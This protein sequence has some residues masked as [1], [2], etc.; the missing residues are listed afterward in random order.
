MDGKINIKDVPQELIDKVRKMVEADPRVRNLR[1][2]QNLLQRKGN[3]IEALKLG[4][5][6]EKMHANVIQ[7]YLLKTEKEYSDIDITLGNV[8]KGDIDELMEIVTTLFLA[9]DIIDTAI[10]DFNDILHK[11]NKDLDMTHFNDIKELADAAK[12]KL[13]YFS[14]HSNMIKDVAFGDKSDNMYTLLRNKARSLIRM[15][16]KRND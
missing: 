7:A 5:E 2:R 10:M 1:I 16:Q 8:S 11:T 9:A 15:R 12:D 6:I 13:K 14:K 3:F 4:K